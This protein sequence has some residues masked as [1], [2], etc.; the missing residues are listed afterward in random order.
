MRYD[1]R[2]SKKTRARIVNVAARHLREHGIESAS[3]KNVMRDAGL[4]HGGFY[5]HFP[6]KESLVIQALIHAFEEVECLLRRAGERGGIAG[7]VQHYLQQPRSGANQGGCPLVALAS[8][9]ARQSN[10]V[11]AAAANEVETYLGVMAQHIGDTDRQ[12][13]R[14]RATQIFSLMMGAVQLACLASN[15]GLATQTLEAAADAA[16]IL[17]SHKL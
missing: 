5:S 12:F 7:I 11:R 6:S 17:S 16:K 2:H 10:E 3:I 14:T 15:E 13:A 8:D 4:T 1:K 9:I